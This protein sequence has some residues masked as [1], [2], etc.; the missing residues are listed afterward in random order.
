MPS[1]APSV[2]KRA[3]AFFDSYHLSEDKSGHSKAVALC[4][5]RIA[6]RMS[7]AGVKV[8]PEEAYAGALLH[9]IGI[10]N[11]P[12]RPPTHKPPAFADQR[13]TSF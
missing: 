3:D 2:R 7:R 5:E 12:H 1:R 11:S 4:A 13:S 9:D 10:A 6:K 8:N